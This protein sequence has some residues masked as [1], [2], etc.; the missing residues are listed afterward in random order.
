[1]PQDPT[2]SYRFKLLSGVHQHGG[3]TYKV[4]QVV[5]SGE[6]LAKR[7]GA[8]KFQRLEDASTSNFG[9]APGPE[10]ALRDD[11]GPA[12]ESGDDQ[13]P[14]TGDE[15][16]DLNVAQLKQYAATHGIELG[17]AT[18]KADLIAAIRAAEDDS[19]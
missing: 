17:G 5:V 8:D 12:P 7:F 18:K 2:R 9:P 10:S 13:L 3:K 16:D 11:T 15:L 19:Q 6:D 14:E 4:G 1:M